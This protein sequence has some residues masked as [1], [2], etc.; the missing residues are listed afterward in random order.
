MLQH[1]RRGFTPVLNIVTGPYLTRSA[2][3]ELFKAQQACLLFSVGHLKRKKQERNRKKAFT[4][5]DGRFSSLFLSATLLFIQCGSWSQFHQFKRK[6]GP[7]LRF[8]PVCFQMSAVRFG[9]LGE[10]PSLLV[11]SD[12]RIYF[13]E[14]TSE[15][16]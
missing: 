2:P 3:R 13:L 9:E 1:L 4:A 6:R 15:N 8:L 5:G 14:M 12:R 7:Q 16:Q 10:V 11:V